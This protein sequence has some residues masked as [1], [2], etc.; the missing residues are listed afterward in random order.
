MYI[1]TVISPVRSLCG[2]NVAQVLPLAFSG[3]AP[4]RS[5]SNLTHNSLYRLFFEVGIPLKMRPG[6]TKELVLGEW[7]RK[8]QHYRC[9]LAPIEAHTPSSN[10]AE[11]SIWE[12]KRS[13]QRLMTR[14]NTPAVLWDFFWTRFTHLISHLFEPWSAWRSSIR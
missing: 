10:L 13:F 4:I 7:K 1:N 14:S 2:N 11:L 9:L 5:R 6:N 12:L 8:L 3:L